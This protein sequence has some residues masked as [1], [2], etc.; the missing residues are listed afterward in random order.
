MDRY[1]LVVL[2]TLAICEYGVSLPCSSFTT[3]RKY[4]FYWIIY[5]ALQTICGL[6]HLLA[7]RNIQLIGPVWI[8]LKIHPK[9]LTI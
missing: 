9:F 6:D 1:E 5:L 7:V 2:K 4:M 8:L 3:C